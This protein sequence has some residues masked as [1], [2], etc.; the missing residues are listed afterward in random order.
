MSQEGSNN[1]GVDRRKVL[2]SIGVASISGTTLGTGNA[3]ATSFETNNLDVAELQG[4]A[5]ENA[6]QKA[7]NTTAFKKYA[8]GFEQESAVKKF[9]L[10]K[11]AKSAF[12]VEND[13]STYSK[14]YVVS[15]SARVKM[16]AKQG[17][18]NTD[19]KSVTADLT[20]TFAD[21]SATGRLVIEEQSNDQ[22]VVRS[23]TY[24]QKE[25]AIEL[26]KQTSNVAKDT[27]E[28]L[29]S[30]K[31]RITNG[32]VKS[33][34]QDT[35]VTA[36]SGQ[37]V[38]SAQSSCFCADVF[39]A[40]CSVGCSVSAGVPCALVTG[41][42]SIYACPVIVGAICAAYIISGSCPPSG[43]TTVE[44]CQQIGYC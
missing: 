2:K 3:S 8:D 22:V 23:V 44:A 32:S 39:S 21:T 19:K 34:E 40:V 10:E 1:S 16:K 7:R 43:L 14:Y 5:R 9:S 27:P 6:V 20:I 18:I 11:T 4:D 37:A 35:K 17:F 26:L 41:P 25:G 28:I 12:R 42:N 38:V 13:K 33:V 29:P 31:V 30:E 36:Q 15:F 24:S